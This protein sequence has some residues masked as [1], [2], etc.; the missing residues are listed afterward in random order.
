MHGQSKAKMDG[1]L[2]AIRYKDKQ[3]IVKYMHKILSVIVNF[4]N[5]C[6]AV[7]MIIHTF[8]SSMVSVLFKFFISRIVYYIHISAFCIPFFRK[9]LLCREVRSNYIAMVLGDC[10]I[11]GV[12]ILQMPSN[13]LCS[14]INTVARR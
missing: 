13:T 1:H 9:I 14:D 10:Y 12:P 3:Y 6:V 5:T 4:V 8:V 7:L 11:A 2:T